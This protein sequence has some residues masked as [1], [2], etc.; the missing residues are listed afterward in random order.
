METPETVDGRHGKDQLNA[1]G[2]NQEYEEEDE[3]QEELKKWS[4]SCR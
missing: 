2:Q 1:F 3:D 4:K